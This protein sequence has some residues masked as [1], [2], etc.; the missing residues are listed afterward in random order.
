MGLASADKVRVRYHLEYPD[1]AQVASAV[2][3]KL[4]YSA[5]MFVLEAMM[6]A[7]NPSSVALVQTQLG[8]LDKIELQMVDALARLQAKSAD[9]VEL[10]H[11]EHGQLLGQYKYWQSRVCKM[12]GVEVNPQATGQRTVNGLNFRIK[13]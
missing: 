11:E 9:V 1:V 7:I 8:Y 10:N 12:L 3:G 4:R 13:S 5:P 2:A 6:D